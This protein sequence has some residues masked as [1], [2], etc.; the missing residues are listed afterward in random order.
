MA[1]PY[2]LPRFVEPELPELTDKTV[3]DCGCGL[4]IWGHLIRIWGNIRVSVI[5]VDNYKPYLRFCHNLN[6]YDDLVLADV[7]FLPFRD[8]AFQIVLAC[9]VIEHLEEKRGHVFLTEIDRI[10]SLKAIVTTPNGFK[11]GADACAHIQSEIHRSRWRVNDFKA[12]GYKVHG[13]GLKYMN[14]YMRF[15]HLWGGL[16]YMFTP[17]SY[18]IPWISE[19]LISVKDYRCFTSS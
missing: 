2:E 11:P 16:R 15:P 17:L 10:C 18:L 3:L 14:F 5:G 1:S 8:K 4:G 12:K 7:S 9:D 19:M 13:I 6:V